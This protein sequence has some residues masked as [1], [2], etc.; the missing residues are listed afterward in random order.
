[1]QNVPSPPGFAQTPRAE[2]CSHV[3]VGARVSARCW[4]WQAANPPIDLLVV[5]GASKVRVAQEHPRQQ[6]IVY[7]VA[8]SN[9]RAMLSQRLRERHWSGTEDMSNPYDNDNYYWFQWI[10]FITMTEM[11]AVR[12][13]STHAEITVRR[14]IGLAFSCRERAARDHV[15]KPRSLARSGRLQRRV[16]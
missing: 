5:P 12:G 15:K 9:W 11:V 1:M 8:A 4:I 13:T 10:W 7:Q 14:R 3:S 6:T 2:A 16:R